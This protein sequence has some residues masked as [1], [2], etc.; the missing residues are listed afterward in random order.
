VLL[1]LELPPPRAVLPRGGSGLEGPV[2]EYTIQQAAQ[3]LQISRT[4]S[5]A[6]IRRLRLGRPNPRIWWSVLI[7]E[8]DLAL[9]GAQV[10]RQ[11]PRPPPPPRPVLTEED[12]ATLAEHLRPTTRGDCLPGG[13]NAERPCPWV[14]CR[15]HLALKVLGSGR[16]RLWHPDLEVWELPETCALDVAD[17]GPESLEKVGAYM[18]LTRERVRQIEEEGLERI[19]KAGIDWEGP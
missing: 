14:G 19:R 17:R 1:L 15:H 13:C 8:A 3:A 5:A 10:R 9:I 6:W 12:L 18:G 2:R 11:T 16:V 4:T 7:T